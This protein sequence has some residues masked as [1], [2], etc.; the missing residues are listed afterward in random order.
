VNPSEVAPFVG[1][2]IAN[3]G[4]WSSIRRNGTS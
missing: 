4:D 2:G 3:L 1:I